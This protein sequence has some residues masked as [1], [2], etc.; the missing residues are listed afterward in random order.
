MLRNWIYVTMILLLAVPP[1]YSD[2]Y[3]LPLPPSN[4]FVELARS[5]WKPG[6][7]C[8]GGCSKLRNM[9]ATSIIISPHLA[10][11]L[12]KEGKILLA[13]TRERKNYNKYHVVGAISL[14]NN[15]VDY[16]K[17]VPRPIPIALY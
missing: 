4:F 5:K 12:L 10:V 13:D 15:E 2:D 6:E 16:M 11:K 3:S 1:V 9:I 14:P 7:P 8:S 17:L